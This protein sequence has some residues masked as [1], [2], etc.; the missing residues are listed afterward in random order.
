MSII[1]AAEAFVKEELAGNDGSHDWWHIHRVRQMALLLAQEEGLP[2][3]PPPNFEPVTTAH[4][5]CV[6]QHCRLAS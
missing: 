5:R 4:C 2:V 3:R 1:A 6:V